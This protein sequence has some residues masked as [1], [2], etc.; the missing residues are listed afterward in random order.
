MLRVLVMQF[1]QCMCLIENE[2]LRSFK[3]RKAFCILRVGFVFQKYILKLI[4]VEV[5]SEI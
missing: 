5:A 1:R 3:L 2:A 4:C